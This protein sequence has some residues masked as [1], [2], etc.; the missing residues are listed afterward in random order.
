MMPM[1][2]HPCKKGSSE[3]MHCSWVKCRSHGKNLPMSLDVKVHYSPTPPQSTPPHT[4]RHL[5]LLPPALAHPQPL[6]HQLTGHTSPLQLAAPRVQLPPTGRH[7]DQE[8][9][10]PQEVVN[11]A[12]GVAGKAGVGRSQ[13][14]Q[15]FTAPTSSSRMRTQAGRRSSGSVPIRRRTS[16]V[17]SVVIRLRRQREDTFRPLCWNCG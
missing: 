8:A 16:G 2:K 15:V 7:L 10:V 14:A 13:P 4:A 9:P 11:L 5:N 1:K 12:V 3:T 17:A 6:R